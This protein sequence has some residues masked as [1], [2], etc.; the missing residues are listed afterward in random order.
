MQWKNSIHKIFE[1]FSKPRKF[2]WKMSTHRSF[3]NTTY[4]WNW[5]TWREC[6]K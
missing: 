3:F 2:V 6:Q 5:R 1:L 4:C